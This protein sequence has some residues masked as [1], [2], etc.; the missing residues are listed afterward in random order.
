MRPVNIVLL[1]LAGAIGG[2]VV[3]KVAQR[4]RAAQVAEL[5][6]A[7]PSE[8]VAPVTAPA[9]AIPQPVTTLAME[10]PAA[11]T[12]EP[13]DAAPAVTPAATRDAARPVEPKASRMR[14][15][16]IVPPKRVEFQ[17]PAERRVASS[18]VPASTPFTS[19]EPVAV[20]EVQPSFQAPVSTP[21]LTPEQPKETPP[22]RMEPENATPVPAPVPPAPDPHTV[23]LNAG[24]LIP[25]RLLDSLSLERNHA[26]DRFAATLESELVAD[27]FVIAERG[28]RVEGK[29]VTADRGAR[30]LSVELTGVETSDNQDVAIQTERFDKRSEPDHAQDATKVGAGAVIG[31]VIGGIAGGGKG[32]AIGAGV[33]G[34]AGAGDVLLTRKPVALASETRITFRLRAPVTITERRD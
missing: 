24:M 20:A 25:V 23:T 15:L 9:P 5:T 32:A 7:T 17:H 8:S 3:M 34:G 33:G 27:R 4:P 21:P 18:S 14:R 28:A 30:T 12:P 29:V 31:A 22:V 1:V 13:V 19:P 16:A 26:G 11:A 6:P 10:P 2:A